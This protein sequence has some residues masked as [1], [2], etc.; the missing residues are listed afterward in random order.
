M[1]LGTSLLSS[2]LVSL[3]IKE[4]DFAGIPYSSVVCHSGVPEFSRPGTQGSWVINLTVKELL[5][6]EAQG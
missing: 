1:T 5:P 2:V 4:S 3:P 6:R